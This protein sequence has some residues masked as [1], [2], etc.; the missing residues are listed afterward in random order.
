MVGATRYTTPTPY[1]PISCPVSHTL[2]G[3][4]VVVCRPSPTVAARPCATPPAIGDDR[5]D[6]GTPLSFPA[7]RRAAT[8][9]PHGTLWIR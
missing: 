3:L 9:A 5:Y 2:P 4:F 1:N 7:P 8:F 6:A